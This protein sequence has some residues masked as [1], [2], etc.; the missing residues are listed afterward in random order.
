M[1]AGWRLDDDRN[2]VAE[3]G[4]A[5]DTV[6]SGRCRNGRRARHERTSCRSSDTHEPCPFLWP[7]DGRYWTGVRSP[8]S[9]SVGKSADQVRNFLALTLMM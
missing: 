1:A 9:V 3:L 8:R 2:A 5:S 4:S 6:E 7:R